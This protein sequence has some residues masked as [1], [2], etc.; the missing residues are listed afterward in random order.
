MV[1]IYF[2]MSIKLNLINNIIVKRHDTG[3]RLMN[4]IGNY[5][6]GWHNRLN[7]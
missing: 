2:K 4:Y 3:A 1:G 5:G 7:K 6:K